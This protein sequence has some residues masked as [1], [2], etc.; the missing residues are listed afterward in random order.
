MCVWGAIYSS[1]DERDLPGKTHSSHSFPIIMT[2]WMV[3]NDRQ[4]VLEP[5]TNTNRAL[6]NA[7]SGHAPNSQTWPNP[8]FHTQYVPPI[9]YPLGGPPLLY[10]PFPTPLWNHR[11]TVRHFQ[12]EMVN[13]PVMTLDNG[14]SAYSIQTRPTRSTP[15]ALPIDYYSL[16]NAN[17]DIYSQTPPHVTSDVPEMFG[18]TPAL[19]AASEK[20]SDVTGTQSSQLVSSWPA[21]CQPYLPCEPP[22]SEVLTYNRQRK[23][24]AAEFEPDPVKLYESCGRY[25][26]S[27]F[28]VN[29]I[30]VVFR[31]G[32][33]KEALL[34]TLHRNE[35]NQMTFQCGFELRQGYDGFISRTG[36]WFVCGLCKE[37]SRTRW[38]HKKDAPRH[39]RKF[40]FGLGDPC[41]VWCIPLASL[42]WPVQILSIDSPL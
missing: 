29:W 23:E 13:H 37:G 26:G 1:R 21:D 15:C 33:T 10:S 22:P 27:A 42:I 7:G 18:S 41:K 30:L 2:A 17:V 19:M 5:L 9:Y 38:K 36:A 8:H 14:S 28:A 11:D 16:T 25:G 24:P 3:E 32:V 39:L 35:M 20:P 12:S 40:H 34:R 31:G 6:D 4:P